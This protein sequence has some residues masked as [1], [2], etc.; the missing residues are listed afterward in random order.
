MSQVQTAPGHFD[1]QAVQQVA[2]VA[3]A[4][5]PAK[6]QPQPVQTVEAATAVREPEPV[7]PVEKQVSQKPTPPAPSVAREPKKVQVPKT[8]TTAAP[9]QA[10]EIAKEMAA[11]RGWTG[12][13][14]EALKDLWHKEA[15]WNMHARN[16]SS[17]ACGIPQ[18]VPCSKIPN[19]KSIHSQIEWGLGY[20]EK[21]YGNPA[22]ALA[23][24]RSRV[25]IN[26]RDVGNW[27]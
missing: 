14:W 9:S 8:L 1:K 26:G 7:K 13:Q 12:Y 19:P 23:F 10:Q 5:T 4:Q 2:G 22:N 21:R 27:Y 6:E 24:W 3:S 11:Q 20:I 17:G 18:A 25:P 16:G 15:G